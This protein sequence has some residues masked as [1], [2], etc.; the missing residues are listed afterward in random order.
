MFLCRR[1]TRNRYKIQNPFNVISAFN[2]I[3]VPFESIDSVS[4]ISSFI[5]LVCFVSLS[6]FFV[7]LCY[8]NEWIIFV[9]TY[10]YIWFSLFIG[11]SRRW[12]KM[13]ETNEHLQ[14]N[15][16]NIEN[17]SIQSERISR[18]KDQNQSERRT[19]IDFVLVALHLMFMYRIWFGVYDQ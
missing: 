8:R 7:T 5:R 9:F 1:S 4:L 6:V 10:T 19:N 17:K 13:C 11:F 18:W 2:Q 3:S 14:S 12:P 16:H 15:N